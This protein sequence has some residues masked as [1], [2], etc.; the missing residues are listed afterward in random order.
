MPRRLPTHR[1]RQILRMK[2]HLGQS[3][4][5]TARRLQISPATV[6]NVVARAQKQALD[7]DRVNF[8]KDAELRL[9]IYPP[10][11]KPDTCRILPAPALIHAALQIP[12]TTLRSLY[13]MYADSTPRAYGYTTFCQHYRA[14]RESRLQSRLP[15]QFPGGKDGE[16][17]P[18]APAMDNRLQRRRD[19]GGRDLLPQA[20]RP[21]RC[22]AQGHEEETAT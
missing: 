21:D 9:Q 15:A 12:D 8:L 3:H 14:W 13:A 2:M 17:S 18:Q 5:Q 11:Q 6:S 10:C 4:R 7:W 20:S 16:V 22:R 1:L 19:T